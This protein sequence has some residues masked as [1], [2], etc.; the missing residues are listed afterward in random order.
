MFRLQ[1]IDQSHQKI[2]DIG[3]RVTQKALVYIDRRDVYLLLV[4]LLSGF[5]GLCTGLLYGLE[6]TKPP[7]TIERFVL[8]R[9]EKLSQNKGN[10]P[11]GAI[12]ATPTV[13]PSTQPVAPA[14]SSNTKTYVASKN[15]KKYHLPTCIGA[16][17]I[18]EAN[19]IWFST[20]TEAEK[21]G[22][23]PATNCKG[24]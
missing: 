22:Y 2:K 17:G 19:R 5:I 23:V 13:Q 4:A 15:G 18:V 7:V 21:A 24:I 12:Q 14:L 16:R 9:P 8:E 1:S 3:L 20:K 11:G 10:E 6:T